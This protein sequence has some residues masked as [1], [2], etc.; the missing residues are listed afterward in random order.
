MITPAELGESQAGQDPVDDG[1][2]DLAQPLRRCAG[3]AK[4]LCQ[5]MT[6]LISFGA[7]VGGVC[8]VKDASDDRELITSR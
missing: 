1:G 7:H 6:E 3:H 2:A 5:L 8:C 4:Q